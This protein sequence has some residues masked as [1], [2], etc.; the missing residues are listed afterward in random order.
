MAHMKKLHSSQAP[1]S[2]NSFGVCITVGST[3]AFS[4]CL[5][6]LNGNTVLFDEFAY[7][8]AVSTSRTLGRTNIGVR[9]DA[10]GMH[11]DDLRKQITLARDKGLD[12]DLG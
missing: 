8:S 3:D 2:D 6:M 7:G 11:P 4:K 10:E 5:T 12:P 1:E 9:M